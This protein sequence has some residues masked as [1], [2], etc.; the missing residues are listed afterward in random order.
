MNGMYRA[1]LDLMRGPAR[2][3]PPVGPQWEEDAHSITLRFCTAGLDPAS[4]RVQV[5]PT[6][7]SV[8]GHRTH[9]ERV[10]APGYFRASSSLSALQRTF[11]L[12][13]PVVPGTAAVRWRGPD[14]LEV[15][16]Q[17]A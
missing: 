17:K 4:V 14:Q 13:C 1:L 6:T 2:E 5:G 8:S 12:P 9:A 15:R 11:R 10:E 3:L 7:V 16:L